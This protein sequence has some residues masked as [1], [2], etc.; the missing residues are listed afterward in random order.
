MP[1]DL[2]TSAV[3]LSPT[4][5]VKAYHK[6][7]RAVVDLAPEAAEQIHDDLA[8]GAPHTHRELAEVRQ[9]IIKAAISLSRPPE[10]SPASSRR[11]YAP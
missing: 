3:M 8:A 7:V 9:Q 10:Q 5:M 4:A 1:E 2:G 6:F 11:G